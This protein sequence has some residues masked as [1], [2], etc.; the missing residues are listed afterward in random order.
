MVCNGFGVRYTSPARLPRA[1]A[2]LVA[3]LDK[4][5]QRLYDPRNSVRGIIRILVQDKRIETIR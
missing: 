1:S 5:R 3:R 2:M 4:Y